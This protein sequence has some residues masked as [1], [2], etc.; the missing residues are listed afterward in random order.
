MELLFAAGLLFVAMAV[1]A[2]LFK[3]LLF[4]IVLPLK[5]AFGLAKGLLGLVI[6]VPLLIVSTLA[7]VGV[8]PVLFIVIAL[9]VLAGLGLLFGLFRLVA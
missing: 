8:L 6:G 4:L 3:F 7:I 2:G 1:V 5:L 9:P